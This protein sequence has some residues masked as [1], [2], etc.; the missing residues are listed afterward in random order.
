MNEIQVDVKKRP[1]EVQKQEED[2]SVSGKEE[3]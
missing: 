3:E 2:K 1:A